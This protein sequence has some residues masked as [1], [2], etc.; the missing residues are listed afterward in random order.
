MTPQYFLDYR[1]ETSRDI[2]I[3]IC[4]GFDDEIHI[5]PLTQKSSGCMKRLFRGLRQ[6]HSKTK[7][8]MI[9]TSDKEKFL[10]SSSD[11]D[12]SESEI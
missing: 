10:P 11:S 5:N 4:R 3:D 1:N 2:K 8:Q 9:D 12:L 6:K 7:Y